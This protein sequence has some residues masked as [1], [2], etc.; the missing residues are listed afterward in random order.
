[1]MCVF[2]MNPLQSSPSPRLS[3]ELTANS[4]KP[5]ISDHTGQG[6]RIVCHVTSRTYQSRGRVLP[7]NSAIG[8]TRRCTLRCVGVKHV[9]RA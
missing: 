5:P 9:H 8:Y 4:V 1:M 2:H 6:G 3:G 7:V